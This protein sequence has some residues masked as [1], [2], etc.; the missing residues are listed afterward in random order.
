M[1]LEKRKRTTFNFKKDSA[2]VNFN[3][4]TAASKPAV[5]PSPSCVGPAASSAPSAAIPPSVCCAAAGYISATA[6]AVRP[7]CRPACC[8]PPPNC[9]CPH[10]F[11]PCTWCPTCG[12]VQLTHSR[13]NPSGFWGAIQQR[14]PC[15]TRRQ[16]F[17]AR[18]VEPRRIRAYL[19]TEDVSFTQ[20]PGSLSSFRGDPRACGV[21]EALLSVIKKCA[22]SKSCPPYGAPSLSRSHLARA[23]PLDA[24]MGA[25][26]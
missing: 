3:D 25:L 5:T 11:W 21:R 10:G 9:P 24:R 15:C 7:R 13:R 12:S 8:S 4:G 17:I 19:E 18:Q 2:W 20:M 1:V 26:G 23:R 14:A 6:A 22:S 16:G